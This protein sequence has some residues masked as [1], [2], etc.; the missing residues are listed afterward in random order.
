MERRAKTGT[1]VWHDGLTRRLKSLLRTAPLHALRGSKAAALLP[2]DDVAALSMKA[3]EILIDALGQSPLPT[4]VVSGVRARISEARQPARPPGFKWLTTPLSGFPSVPFI[5]SSLLRERR[6]LSWSRYSSRAPNS[7]S[8]LRRG[9]Y[10][11]RQKRCCSACCCTRGRSRRVSMPPSFAVAFPPSSKS[12][13]ADS[14][15]TALSGSSATLPLT[16]VRIMGSITG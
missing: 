10:Q 13:P 2:H 6:L 5:P 8:S 7:R 3:L 1:P 16:F 9:R 11:S 12:S 14:A 4:A 15:S